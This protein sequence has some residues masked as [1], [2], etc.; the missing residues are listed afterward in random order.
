MWITYI[1]ARGFHSPPDH[2]FCKIC[3]PARSYFHYTRP[4]T[5]SPLSPPI[6]L[7][8]VMLMVYCVSPH[9]LGFKP[10]RSR[11]FYSF[12]QGC[13]PNGTE[14][15]LNICWM[16]ECNTSHNGQRWGHLFRWIWFIWRKVLNQY[17]GGSVKLFLLLLGLTFQ[18]KRHV[19]SKSILK[20]KKKNRKGAGE[21]SKLAVLEDNF[22]NWLKNKRKKFQSPTASNLSEWVFL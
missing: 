22:A 21:N 11:D 2:I 1:D 6:H 3:A 9:P 13:I 18:P 4:W 16:D 14:W 19:K 8:I 17:V 20:K 10:H 15:A 12:V 5:F 7:H